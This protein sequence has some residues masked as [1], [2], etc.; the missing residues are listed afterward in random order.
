MKIDQTAFANSGPLSLQA[1]LDEA[2]KAGSIPQKRLPRIRAALAA[3]IR[4]MARPP[5]ELPAH[6]GFVIQQTKRLR[7]RPTGISLKTLSNTRSELLFLISTVSGKSPATWKK[8][9]PEWD[10]FGETL[11]G[12]RAWWSLSRFAAYCSTEDVV[13]T[14]VSD[15][16]VTRFA[17]YLEDSGE[18]ETPKAHVRRVIAVWN[19]VASQYPQ[20]R[21]P[22]LTSTPQGRKRW[23]IPE[24]QYND[25][26]RQD[27]EKWLARLTNPDPFAPGPSRP[28]RPAT[29]RIR[30]HQLFKAASALVF[31]GHRI[32]TIRSLADLVRIENFQTLMRYLLARQS[33]STEALYNLSY[34]LLA[35][36]RHHVQVD[37]ETDAKLAR[38]VKNLSSD[39]VGFRSRT[40]TRLAAFEDDRLLAALFQLPAKLLNDARKVRS[41]YRQR[42]L[43][44]LAIAIEILTFAP[45][46]VGNLSSLR[47]GETL[48]KVSV[49]NQTCWLI[50]IPA[51]EV[52]NRQELI[53]ELPAKDHP[54]I[55]DAL[56]LYSQPEGWVFGGR[57]GPKTALSKLIKQ[58]IER[59]LGVAFHTHMFRALAGYVHLREN[60]NGFESVRALLGNRDEHVVRRNYAF[61]AERSHI[62]HAQETIRSNRAR[63]AATHVEKKKR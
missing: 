32:D 16:R 17:T 20:M 33:Q 59:H 45:L 57:K 60:P 9:S 18:V 63:F 53:H 52:K 11:C 43:A 49:R 25:E 8:F 5:N 44:Q 24:Q 31:S 26:F 2:I 15:Q 3:F 42:I 48:R 40:R 50:T 1:A 22:A 21:L 39:V 28:L 36:A 30:R 6:R 56:R 23:T 37:K 58:I 27:V 55:A 13:P 41:P 12:Q 47:L 19:K 61:M 34:A 62:A 10:A 51:A 4:L 54:L 29:I 14:Q 46:R 38:L 35:V 7:R